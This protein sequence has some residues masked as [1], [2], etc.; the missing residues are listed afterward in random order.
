MSSPCMFVLTPDCHPKKL[1]NKNKL[2][3]GTSKNKVTIKCKVAVAEWVT[4]RSICKGRSAAVL[5]Q[6]NISD[7]CGN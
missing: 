7:P 3:H 1:P 5:S 4:L 2:M 6:R